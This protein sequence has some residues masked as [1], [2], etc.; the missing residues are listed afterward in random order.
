MVDVATL[1]AD[2]RHPAEPTRARRAPPQGRSRA[3]GSPAVERAAPG[4]PPTAV[5]VPTRQQRKAAQRLQARKVG[6][7]VRHIDLWSVGKVALLFNLCLFIVLIVSGTV[8]WR[9]CRAIGLLGGIEGFIEE[10]FALRSFAFDGGQV[11]QVAT[12]G[13]LALAVGCTIVACLAALLF[14]LISDLVGGVRLTVVEEETARPRP[15]R[16]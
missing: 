8:L 14:N 9:L 16:R 12:F 1:L 4:P 5:A 13:G 2:P 11:F 6:R 3:A 15:P 10:A 7:L